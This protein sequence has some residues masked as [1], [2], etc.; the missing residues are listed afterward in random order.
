MGY[1]GYHGTPVDTLGV[2]WIS[3]YSCGYLG[4]TV[5]NMGVLWVSWYLC[6]YLGDTLS[7][8][9]IHGSH[10]S[11]IMPSSSTDGLPSVYHEC[12]NTLHVQSV[13]YGM[14]FFS[15]VPLVTVQVIQHQLALNTR[16][17]Q[18]Q[19][20]HN[21]AIA[22]IDRLPSQTYSALINSTLALLAL[23]L[24]TTNNKMTP[25]F[26]AVLKTRDSPHTKTGSTKYEVTRSK[27][28]SSKKSGSSAVW[29]PKLLVFYILANIFFKLPSSKL[30]HFA[31]KEQVYS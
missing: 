14:L 11:P 23:S 16:D 26:P 8:L 29:I 2:L 28:A 25:D 7:T 27:G 17:Y 30:I 4:H 9:G 13:Y 24:Q 15:A 10:N 1:C 6:E 20:N 3:W 5:D 31:I 22:I 21:L 19:P 12:C 18:P